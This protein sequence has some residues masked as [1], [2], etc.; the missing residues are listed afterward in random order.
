MN[1]S[2][3]VQALA[4]WL[5]PLI[6][7]LQPAERRSL[8]ARIALDLRRQNQER[9]RA[10]VAPDGTPWQARRARIVLQHGL[11]EGAA[12]A[13]KRRGPMMV[14]LRQA[15]YLPTTAT[16]DEAAITFAG[17]VL[18][19]A[20]VHHFGLPDRVAEDGPVHTYD[21]R[22]LLGLSDDGI[23]HI[24]TLVLDHLASAVRG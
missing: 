15:R 13:R 24:K 1:A 19:I 7:A 18:R 8:A 11:R 4:T 22:P 6:A 2:D 3:D 5:Q 20:R 9:M 14:K 23:E 12:R 10:Q 21:A 17:R 16:P